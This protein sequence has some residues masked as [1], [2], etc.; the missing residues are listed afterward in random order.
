ML[1]SLLSLPSWTPGSLT[2]ATL[3]PSPSVPRRPLEDPTQVTPPGQSSCPPFPLLP[4]CDPRGSRSLAQE[5]CVPHRNSHGTPL[6]SGPLTTHLTLRQDPD[7][8]T[9]EVS[10]PPGL[11]EAF[12]SPFVPSGRYLSTGLRSLLSPL[13]QS[14]A[15]GALLHG[16][17]LPFF[18][19][20]GSLP[21]IQDTFRLFPGK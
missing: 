1:P 2:P 19:S 17:N 14:R 12:L 20:G 21:T 11:P 7:S 8:S 13:T 5:R 15:L 18:V 3:P 16:A 9:E 4:R 10:H 6:D